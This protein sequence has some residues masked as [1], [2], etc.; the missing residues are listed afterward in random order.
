MISD[1]HAKQCFTDYWEVA[2]YYMNTDASNCAT[3]PHTTDCAGLI[4]I[5]I[6]ALNV[7]ATLG[8]P[9]ECKIDGQ[10]DIFSQV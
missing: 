9:A 1:D 3:T 2:K 4:S 8:L 7:G 6:N 5:I 10:T